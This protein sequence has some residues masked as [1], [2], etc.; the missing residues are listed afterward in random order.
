MDDAGQQDDIVGNRM[1]VVPAIAVYKAKTRKVGIRGRLGVTASSITGAPEQT[2]TE[3]SLGI[4]TVTGARLEAMLGASDLGPRSGRPLDYERKTVGVGDHRLMVSTQALIGVMR[5]RSA[6]GE[7]GEKAGRVLVWKWSYDD[8]DEIRVGRV[9]K[10]FKLWDVVLQI[11][12][13][14]P[15]ASLGYSGY[16][17][18]PDIFTSY[19]SVAKAAKVDG[20]HLLGFA[21]T[22]STAIARHRGCE[23]VRSSDDDPK[24]PFDTFSFAAVASGGGR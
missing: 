12:C 22:L 10:M 6:W 7:S 15:E 21:T 8:I 23:V 20:S 5:G 17:N 24:E 9:K 14:D 13:R 19:E 18:D 4:W 1:T 2:E 16:G 3:P 11:T